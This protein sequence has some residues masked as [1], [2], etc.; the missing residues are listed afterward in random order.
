M[1]VDKA[2]AFALIFDQRA[3]ALFAIP[4]GF[5]GALTFPQFALGL[6]DQAAVLDRN[7]SLIG[8][9]ADQ[10]DL[11][12]GEHARLGIFDSSTRR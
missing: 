2:D 11:F 6:L 7:G 10:V 5:F 12:F 8:E 4:Q 1:V 9:H 3:I